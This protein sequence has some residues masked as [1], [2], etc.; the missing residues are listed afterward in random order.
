MLDAKNVNREAHLDG[1]ASVPE[2]AYERRHADAR[3][4]WSP[5]DSLGEKAAVGLTGKVGR[6]PGVTDHFR[7]E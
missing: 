2:D 3:G 4:A 5:G 1:D 6:E 7:R